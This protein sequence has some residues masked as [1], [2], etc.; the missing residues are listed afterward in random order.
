MAENEIQIG[1]KVI[2]EGTKISLT[3]KTAIWIISGVIV[4][5]S[6]L[7]TVAYYDLK[8]DIQINK[9][10]FDSQLDIKIGKL[11]DKNEAISSDVSDIKGDIKVILDRTGRM[12][13][14][15]TETPN[16]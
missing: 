6:S 11:N 12:Q 2:G 3:V 16:P 14:D 4:L 7:F 9:E 1:D 8:T 15:N 10:Q 13:L 5:F